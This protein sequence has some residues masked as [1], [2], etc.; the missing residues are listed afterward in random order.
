VCQANQCGKAVVY[1]G[2][3]IGILMSSRMYG[4][5]GIYGMYVWYFLRY[6]MYG[7]CILMNVI[8]CSSP[9]LLVCQ[10][11]LPGGGGQLYTSVQG[12][13][14]VLQSAVMCVFVLL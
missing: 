6:G 1:I 5:Y 9:Q 7:T 2:L 4:M 3:Y 11:G 8:A 14:D 10:A 12:G 13:L